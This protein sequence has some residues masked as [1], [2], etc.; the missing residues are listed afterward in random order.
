MS[1]NKE[2]AKKTAA[3]N[4]KKYGSDYYAKIGRKGGLSKSKKKNVQPK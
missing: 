4:K 2:G 3:T 1:G